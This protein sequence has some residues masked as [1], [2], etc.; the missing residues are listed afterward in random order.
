M[1]AHI[2]GMLNV[3]WSK[4]EIVETYMN[5]PEIGI[6]VLIFDNKILEQNENGVCLRTTHSEL[7]TTRST[8]FHNNFSR[9]IGL[10]HLEQIISRRIIMIRPYIFSIDMMKT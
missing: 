10:K 6:G 8:I 5:Y 4:Q 2:N 7:T 9:L 1:Y 3:G